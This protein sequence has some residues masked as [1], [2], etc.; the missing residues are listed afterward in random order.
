MTFCEALHS[1]R[2]TVRSEEGTEVRV[3]D[4]GVLFVWLS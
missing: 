1:D 4:G 2:P 3:T